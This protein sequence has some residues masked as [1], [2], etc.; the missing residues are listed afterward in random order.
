MA[1]KR[2]YCT[3]W[4]NAPEDVNSCCHQHDR[5]Y[6]SRGTVSRA[7]ADRR[8]RQC[9]AAGGRPALAWLLWAALRIGGWYWWKDKAATTG[10]AAPMEQE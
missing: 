10:E 3:G 5:D 8:L 1:N 4:T 7:E 2:T 9:V 6:G